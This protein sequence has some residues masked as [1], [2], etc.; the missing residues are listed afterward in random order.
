MV[1]ELRGVTKTYGTVVAVNGLSIELD[2]GQV[3]AILGPNGAGKTTAV[4]L[5]MGLTRPTTGTVRLFGRDPRATRRRRRV[6][7]HAADR[8]GP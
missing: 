2:E 8:Q 3:T 1:A 6:G 7:C 4:R 5:L